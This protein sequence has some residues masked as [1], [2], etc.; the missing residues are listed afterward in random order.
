MAAALVPVLLSPGDGA[1]WPLAAAAPALGAWGLA[2]AWPGVAGLS[3]RAHRRAA[4]G[5]TGCLW[6]ALATRPVAVGASLPDG[7]HNVLTPLATTGT[8]AAAAIWAGAA[9]T[10]PLTRSRRW[11]ALECVRL[12]IWAL[13]LGLATVAAEH[14]NGVPPGRT[15]LLGAAVGAAVALI[16]R[17]SAAGL[18]AARSGNDQP[19]TS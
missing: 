13:A 3:A 19:T 10:L 1:A 8:L 15:A 2:A 17:R 9:L 12:G 7:L 4:L 11:P 18:R 14:L 5:A 6:A 16:A